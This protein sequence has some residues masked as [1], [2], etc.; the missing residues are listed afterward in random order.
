MKKIKEFFNDL[1]ILISF[2]SVIESIF[3]VVVYLIL[4]LWISCSVSLTAVKGDNNLIDK[5][6]E[7]QVKP[8]GDIDRN[9]T[10]DFDNDTLYQY[11]SSRFK[12]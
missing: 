6:I 1:S 4:M 10:I 8:K 2:K 3:L 11:I 12:C 9:S 5:N 7:N